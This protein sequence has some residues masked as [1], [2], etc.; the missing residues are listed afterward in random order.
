MRSF[1]VIISIM[2]SSATAHAQF[3]PF[4]NSKAVLPWV[5]NP[6]ADIPHDLQAYVG[7]DGRGNSDFTPQSVVAGVRVPIS[8][9]DRSRY[10]VPGGVAGVQVLNTSQTLWNTLTVNLNFAKQIQLSRGSRVAFGMGA[11]I[12]NM[13]YDQSALIYF[14]PQDPLL[15]TGENLFNIHLNAGVSLVLADRF[16]AQLAAPYI[17]KDKGVNITEIILRTGYVFPVHPE[18]N[19]IAAVNLDTYNNH[20]IYGGDLRMEFREVFSVMAGLDTEKYH[21]GLLVKFDA[22]GFGYTYGENFSGLLNNIPS[23]QLSV[24]ANFQGMDLWGW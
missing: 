21:G 23:H 22:F 6:T 9:G 19:L 2:L 11:G 7:Y 5:Y 3:R 16:F 15:N 20:L 13:N 10:S 24:I 8:G 18:A 14:D 12:Y 4:D 1:I 17:L